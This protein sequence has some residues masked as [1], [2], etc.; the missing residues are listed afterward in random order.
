MTRSSAGLVV[1][2]TAILG[3]GVA[4]AVEDPIKERKQLMKGNGEAVKGIVAVFKGEKPYD[5][6]DA[7]K[8][9][10]EINKSL[11]TFVTLFPKGSETGEDTAAK[12]EIWD[13]KAEFESKAKDLEEATAKA[14]AAAT[15]GFDSF[16]VAFGDVGKAC[17]ACHEKFRI[18]K[19]EK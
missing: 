6:E 15:G 4:L 7:A 12:P 10:T 3:T 13:D 19:E 14:A 1:V 8:A 11:A 9:M 16:K 5:A 2:L 17:K 18:K